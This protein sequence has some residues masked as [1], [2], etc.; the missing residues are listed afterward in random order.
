MTGTINAEMLPAI[1]DFSDRN[2]VVNCTTC[3][4]GDI[5]PATRME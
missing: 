5:T 3:H 4:R 2:A 1:T